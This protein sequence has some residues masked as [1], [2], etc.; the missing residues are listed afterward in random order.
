MAIALS[1]YGLSSGE[2][3]A[4]RL[5]VPFS[6]KTSRDFLKKDRFRRIPFSVMSKVSAIYVFRSVFFILGKVVF[7][8]FE[9]AIFL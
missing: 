2:N 8:I 6:F 9:D 1:S 4:I 7:W 3:S 5:Q